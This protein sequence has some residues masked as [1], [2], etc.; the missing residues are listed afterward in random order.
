MSNDNYV[1]MEQL[2]QNLECKNKDNVFCQNRIFHTLGYRPVPVESQQQYLQS[3]TNITM[4]DTTNNDTSTAPSE[5]RIEDNT[6][7][8][9]TY[10]NI[11]TDTRTEDISTTQQPNQRFKSAVRRVQNI[12]RTTSSDITQTPQSNR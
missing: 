6:T 8:T 1:S 10:N 7:D 9:S 11:N 5:F 2:C 12:T 4:T 3:D